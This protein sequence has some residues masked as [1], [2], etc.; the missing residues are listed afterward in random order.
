M[1]DAGEDEGGEEDGG[2]DDGFEL[3]DEGERLLGRGLGGCGGAQEEDG[4]VDAEEGEG[5]GEDDGEEEE[6]PAGAETLGAKKGS[7]TVAWEL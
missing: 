3:E 6:G 2:E 4:G 5:G 7:G 1:L